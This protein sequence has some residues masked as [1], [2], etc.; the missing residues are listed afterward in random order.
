MPRKV[1][2][3]TGKTI[4]GFKIVCREQS[5]KEGVYWK[6]ICPIC[7]GYGMAKR[8]NLKTNKSCGCLRKKR[9][10][11]FL[12]ERN[13]TH[14]ESRTKLYVCWRN[15]INR[16]QNKNNKSYKN[17]GGRGITVCKEWE[18]FMAFK[19]WA[20]Q[21]GY[22][23]GLTLERVDNE[24][25]YNPDNCIWADW[26]TQNNNKQQSRKETYKG[27]TKTVNQWAEEYDMS[28]QTLLGRL[29]R[30]MTIKQALETPISGGKRSG[31]RQ[32]TGK[33]K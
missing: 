3:L 19:E 25:G 13:T 10:S 9:S 33:R 27:E 31:Y 21:N 23:K 6:F 11:D 15:M 8:E 18:D 28:Y 4:N 1:E 14:G 22:K 20:L 12:K 24:K 32:P 7:G 29:N 17:Y 26:K 30:G 2:D 16:T 5:E